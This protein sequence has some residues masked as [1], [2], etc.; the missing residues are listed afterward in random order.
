[1]GQ[2]AGE[3]ADIV[4]ITDVNCFDE[5]PRVIAEMLAVGARAVGKIDDVNLFIEVDRR[6]GIRKAINLAKAGDIV[7]ITA[8]GAEPVLCIAHGVKLPWDDRQVARED[9]A[10]AGSQA[11]KR[12]ESV[13]VGDEVEVHVDGLTRSVELPDDFAG[14]FRDAC[15]VN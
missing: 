4:V 11:R 12:E 6:A 3:L 5:N 9:A 13:P 1:M 8:K 7:A 14:Q 10:Q 2:I 15:P